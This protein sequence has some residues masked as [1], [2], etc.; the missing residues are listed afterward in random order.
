MLLEKNAAFTAIKRYAV[1]SILRTV[2]T[3]AA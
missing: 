2:A 3:V 1:M